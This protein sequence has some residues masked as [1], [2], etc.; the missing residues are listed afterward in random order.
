MSC[1]IPSSLIQSHL[2]QGVAKHG[3]E[4][5]QARWLYVKAEPKLSTA[6]SA[7]ISSDGSLLSGSGS[8]SGEAGKRKPNKARK[9]PNAKRASRMDV[10]AMDH[11]ALAGAADSYRG[12]GAA[13][14]SGSEEQKKAAMAHVVAW[15]GAQLVRNLRRNDLAGHS[16]P[17]LLI[18]VSASDALDVNL[19][20]LRLSPGTPVSINVLAARAIPAHLGVE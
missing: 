11:A 7:P 1:N 16:T 5:L 4:W 13:A 3:P 18:F 20:P 19:L 12:Q 17:L 2:Q 6:G 9:Q 8:F 15:L 14:A 10:D